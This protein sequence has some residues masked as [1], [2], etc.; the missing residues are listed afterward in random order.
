[1]RLLITFLFLITI[2]WACARTQTLDTLRQSLK[3]HSTEDSIHVDLFNQLSFRILKYQPENSFDYA[4]RALTLAQRLKFQKGIGEAKNNLAVYH[5]L[6]GKADV[7]LGE[8]FEAVKIGEQKQ[9]TELLAN[10]YA[11]LGSIY[12]NQLNYDKA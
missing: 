10:S 7:A 8:A 9:S 12:H 4:Q 2:F 6:K 5:L 11:I 3:E 1:M